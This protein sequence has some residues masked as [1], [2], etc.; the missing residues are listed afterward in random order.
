MPAHQPEELDELFVQALNS[1]DLHALV[2]LY[3]PEG[4]ISQDY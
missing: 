3:E 2:A 4:C 1:D